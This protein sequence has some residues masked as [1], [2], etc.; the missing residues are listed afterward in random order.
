MEYRCDTCETTFATLPP[1]GRCPRCD[2]AVRPQTDA[3]HGD[4]LRPPEDGPKKR[5][6]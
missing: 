5:P 3:R 4:A 2:A 6:A 1:Q